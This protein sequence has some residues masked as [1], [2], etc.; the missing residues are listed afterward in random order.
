[1]ATIEFDQQANSLQVNPHP[2]VL[3]TGQTAVWQFLGL[4]SGYSVSFEF[5]H[6]GSSGPFASFILT[7]EE[8]VGAD[9]DPISPTA[10]FQSQVSYSVKVLD[11]NGDLVASLP[12][13]LIDTLGDPPGGLV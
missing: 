11:G 4:P 2:L 5:D 10:G 3:S 13:P 6:F 8:A 7:E 9:Y 1:M 12:D